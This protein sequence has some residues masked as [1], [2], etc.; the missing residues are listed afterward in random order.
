MKNEFDKGK[1]NYTPLNNG[2]L[3]LP[4]DNMNSIAELT[5]NV[6]TLELCLGSLLMG[7]LVS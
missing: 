2:P 4:E 7:A 3:N 1:K 6:L 5:M